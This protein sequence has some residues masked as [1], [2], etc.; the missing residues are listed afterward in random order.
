[1]PRTTLRTDSVFPGGSCPFIL[2]KC[3]IAA[4]RLPIV[5]DFSPAVAWLERNR[6]TVPAEAGIGSSPRASHHAVKIAEVRAVG[7]AGAGALLVLREGQGGGHLGIGQ[8]RGKGGNR[9]D[10]DEGVHN[11]G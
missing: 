10:N 1:M 7:P 4:A 9:R 2:W 6:A 5:D 11:S 3:A 8:G